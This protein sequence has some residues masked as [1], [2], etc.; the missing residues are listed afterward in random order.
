MAATSSDVA[1]GQKSTD[2]SRLDPITFAVA[3]NGLMHAANQMAATFTRTAMLAILYE[4]RDFGASLFDRDVNVIADSPGLPIFIGS[5]EVAVK[6]ALEEIGG[7]GTLEPGDVILTNNPHYTGGQPV[8]LAVFQPIIIDGEVLGYAALRGHMGDLGAKNLYPSDST[9]AFQEGIIFPPIK[10]RAG[11]TVNQDVIKT[12]EI[13]SRM[14]KETAGSVLGAMAA[15][16]VAVEEVAKVVDRHGLDV[17]EQTVTELLDHGERFARSAIAEI[18]DGTYVVERFLDSDGLTEEPIPL[19]CALTIK[20]TDLNIN[21][22]GSAP[23]QRGPVNCP[24]AYIMSACKLAM[25]RVISPDLAPNSGEA[26]PLSITVPPESIFDP[27]WPAATFLG[28]F[29]ALRLSDMIMMAFAQALPDRLPAENA[30][31]MVQMV[32]YLRDPET[33]DLSFFVDMGMSGH[34]GLKSH[35]GL[36]AAVHPIQ[37]GCLNIPIELVETRMPVRKLRFELVQDSGGPGEFRGGVTTTG[38]W[39]ILGEGPSTV[40]AE[41]RKSARVEGLAGGKPAPFT[42]S[43]TLFPGTEKEQVL[44]KKSDVMF[45]PGDRFILTPAGGGGWGDPLNRDLNRVVEDVAEGLVSVEGA[46]RDYGVVIRADGSADKDQTTALRSR[47]RS[48]GG[49][50]DE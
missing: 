38:E 11:S 29:T 47:M 22:E 14:P 33:K 1:T 39:E 16:S 8:D 10:I 24:M 6:K 15:L 27:A 4:Y 37:A 18:P 23:Q 50:D 30:G 40:V 45:E 20:G 21:L 31:D 49:V 17:Y 19:R 9:D 12:I 34:G 36:S 2:G 46:R 32:A 35:D 48:E 28:P 44:G 42:N 43:V 13:N 41:K 5:L 3:R 26:R 7:P 25:K